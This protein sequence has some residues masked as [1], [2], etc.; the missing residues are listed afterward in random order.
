M[1]PSLLNKFLSSESSFEAF[2]LSAM[3]LARQGAQTLISSVSS[4]D[5]LLCTLIKYNEFGVNDTDIDELVA[6]N[7]L[8]LSQT[9]ALNRTPIQLLGSLWNG[10]SCNSPD[11]P[12]AMG[13]RTFRKTAMILVRRGADVFNVTVANPNQTLLH[14]FLLGTGLN[15]EDNPEIEAQIEEL[16]HLHPGIIHAIGPGNCTPLQRFML[17]NVSPFPVF[18]KIAMSL[19]RRGAVSSLSDGHGLLS[20][21]IR[22]N[23]DGINDAEINELIAL[24]PDALTI[25]TRDNDTLLHSACNGGSL[26]NIRLLLEHDIDVNARN[27]RGKTAAHLAAPSKNM[28]ILK[29]L[30]EAGADFTIADNLGN[31]PDI[32]LIHSKTQ[33][34]LRQIQA[35]RTYGLKLS[36]E[37]ASKGEIVVT[38]ADRLTD[39]LQTFI[40]KFELCSKAEER[41]LYDA[42]QTEFTTLL[43][44]EDEAMSSYRFSW[45]TIINNILFVFLSFGSGLILIPLQLIVSRVTE[46]RFLFFG[47]RSKTTSECL[48]RDIEGS[49]QSLSRVMSTA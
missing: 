36:S 49:S 32:G 15:G 23:K 14:I 17:S 5:T 46:G 30:K 28:N 1:R 42:F 7:P 12:G 29:L 4:G 24:D 22:L 25:I 39:S 31:K 41:D 9:D 20:F 45:E 48:I 26:S 34:L 38:L 44:S 27:S 18:K 11:R 37:G 13:F 10:S 35:M 19:V 21:L 47:Q 6:A 40:S 2:K 16:I 43:H 8:L 33:P 3:T